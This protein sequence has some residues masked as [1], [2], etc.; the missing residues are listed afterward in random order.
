MHDRKDKIVLTVAQL[1]E[2]IGAELCGSGQPEITGV[3]TVANAGQTQVCF[4]TSQKHIAGL[5]DSSAIAVI[6]SEKIEAI[7]IAQLIVKDV[8]ATLITVLNL[9]APKLTP[10]EGIHPAAVVEESA[11]IGSNVAIGPGAYISHGVTIGDGTIIAQGCSIGENTTIGQNSRI[12][13]NVVVYRQCTIGNNCNILANTTIG[14]TGFGY[15]F[16]DGQHRLVP[17]NGGVLVEDCVDI[18]ANCCIDRAKFGNTVIGAGTKI[19]NLCQIAHNVVLGKCCLLASMVGISGSCTF[20][21]GVVVSGQSG[22]RDHINVGSGAMLGAGAGVLEDI[23]AGK[24]VLGLPAVDAKQEIKFWLAKRRLPGMVRQ[25][26][27]LTA[28]VD[29]LEASIKSE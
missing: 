22:V 20:G 5:T 12:D 9:F 26:K 17:H 25:L 27:R 19:D 1:A 11:K 13:A 18:G 21:D 15:S 16:I 8:N 10:L 3:N 23:E 4:I 29:K 14:A 7:D 6:V 28:K 24:T 2:K